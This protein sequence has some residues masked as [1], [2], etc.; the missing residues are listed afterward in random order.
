MNEQDKSNQ[1]PSDENKTFA[2]GQTGQ[3]GQ[4]QSGQTPQAPELSQSEPKSAF[5]QDGET[6]TDQRTD[7]T[8]DASQATGEEAQQEGFVGQQRDDSGEYLR[9]EETG[10]SDSEATGSTEPSKL[11]GQ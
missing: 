1:N 8:S 5:A 10:E 3:G 6:A 9:K 2:T 11:D 7:I 4:G